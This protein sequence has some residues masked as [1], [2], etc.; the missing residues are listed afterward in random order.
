MLSPKIL[1]NRAH[2]SFATTEKRRDGEYPVIALLSGTPSQKQK[3]G[4]NL[5]QVNGGTERG[6]RR[7]VQMG[8]RD[9]PNTKK[10]ALPTT[11]REV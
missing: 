11:T 3:R 8:V 7:R 9:R 4:R 5:C 1:Y 10:L 6:C 2:R